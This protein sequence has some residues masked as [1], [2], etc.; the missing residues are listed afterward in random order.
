MG[1]RKYGMIDNVLSNVT[2]EYKMGESKR[3]YEFF[4]ACYLYLYEK[5]L[6]PAIDIF[7]DLKKYIDTNQQFNP[8]LG[9][10]MDQM[11]ADA[12]VDMDLLGL[13]RDAFTLS[14]VNF[15]LGECYDE[16]GKRDKAKD[17]WNG[18]ITAS[19]NSYWSKQARARLMAQ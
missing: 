1:T 7:E 15:R 11:M 14:E 2:D 16:Y 5:K 19:P 4:Q 13:K 17:A 10:L 8:A 3:D 9:G 18:A 12:G 6:G